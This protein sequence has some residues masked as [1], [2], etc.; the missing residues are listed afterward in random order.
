MIDCGAIEEYKYLLDQITSMGINKIK[1]LFI[2]HS[3]DDHIGC[4]VEFI[5]RFK[6]EKV[7]LKSIDV[8]FRSFVDQDPVDQQP[9]HDRLISYC[10]TNNVELVEVTS[11]EI[12]ISNHELIKPLGHDYSN[13]QNYNFE[14]LM[15]LYKYKNT[16]VLFGG[17][18]PRE[19]Q[20]FILG[21]HN[22]PRVDL[23]KACH[24]GNNDCM[25]RNL[26]T[27]V[28]PTNNVINCFDHLTHEFIKLSQFYELNCYSYAPGEN[29]GT[30]SF[31]VGANG[32][33][34]SGKRKILSNVWS[35]KTI[36]GIRDIYFKDGGLPARDEVIRYKNDYY[37]IGENYGMVRGDFIEKNKGEQTAYYYAGEDGVLYREKWFKY[38]NTENLCY[39]KNNLICAY[40][41]SL[42]IDGEKRYFDP[43]GMCTNPPSDI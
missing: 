8:N 29:K 24:H 13:K 1:Y 33:A 34:T 2:T 43:N 32:V 27:S 4:A 12:S 35:N 7:F 16:H 19:T 10:R 37:Y 14:S 28:F 36:D 30:L 40:N 11:Q 9:F 22:L 18:C 20:D 31:I 39:A 26:I 25:N 6:I 5:E 38:R 3:H 17:D 15:Y 21:K 23:F 41:E 42:Y